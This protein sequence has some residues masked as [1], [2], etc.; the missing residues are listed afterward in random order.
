MKLSLD[1]RDLPSLIE[2][3]STDHCSPIA[4]G[5]DGFLDRIHHAVRARD[6]TGMLRMKTVEELRN[7]IVPGQ[8][9]NVE[10]TL[11][12]ERIGGNGALLAGALGALGI[13]TTLLANLSNNHE[14]LQIA[15]PFLP[16][17]QK[18]VKLWSYGQFAV[19]DALEFVDGKLFFGQMAGLLQLRWEQLQDRI[20]QQALLQF[21]KSPIVCLTNWTMIPFSNEVWKG[22]SSFGEGPKWVFVD[23][24]EP[25]KRSD[26]DLQEA[27]TILQGMPAKVVLGLNERE[28]LRVA[29]LS[30]APPELDL[31]ERLEMIQRVWGLE[32]VVLHTR[33]RA[34]WQGQEQQVL[35]WQPF[36]QPRTLTGAGDHFNAGLVAALSR[37]CDP[38]L[39]L[40]AGVAVAQFW[41]QHGEDLSRPEFLAQLRKQIGDQKHP[42]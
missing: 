4:V 6:Q 24:A 41:I 32:A 1:V 33:D 16:L 2:A 12:A 19:T 13:P 30:K 22:F 25:A 29:S 39:C 28:S 36:A 10:W 17:L 9:A 34:I 42:I 40:L 23:L 35:Q 20:G 5:L 14:D 31:G 3:F 8:S 21:W 37:G 15:E 18:G 38:R 27:L 26:Q 11:E 7:R